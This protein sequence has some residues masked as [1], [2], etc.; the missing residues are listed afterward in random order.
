M[1]FVGEI[2]RRADF[3]L[4]RYLRTRTNHDLGARIRRI[5]FF[6]KYGK[7]WNNFKSYISIGILSHIPR[8]NM[9]NNI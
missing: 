5:H 8:G 2:P 7:K 1:R 4:Q 3:W 9:A 6:F